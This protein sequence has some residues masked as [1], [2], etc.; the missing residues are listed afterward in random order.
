M[1]WWKILL[2]VIAVMMCLVD[3]VREIARTKDSKHKE[4]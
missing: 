2:I 3:T 4:D 1:E